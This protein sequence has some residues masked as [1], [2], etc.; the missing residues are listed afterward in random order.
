[1]YVLGV[2]TSCDET[3]CAVVQ[4]GKKILS[5]IVAS[6][7]EDHKPYGGI[8]PEIA[9]RSHVEFM[10]AVLERALKKARLCYEDIGLISVTNGP[11]LPGSLLVGLATAKALSFAKKIPLLGVDHL[12]A[13]LYACLMRPRPPRFPLVGMVVSG[14]HTSIFNIEAVDRFK[15]IAET[16]DDACGEAFDKVAKMLGLGY[17]GGPLIERRARAGN[18][19]AFSFPPPIAH[20]H[21][22]NFSFSGIKTAVLYKIKELQGM[23]IQPKGKRR[24]KDA[25]PP[26]P[27]R[28]SVIDD[29]CASFQKVVIETLMQRAQ[30]ACERFCA[31][32]LLLGG[33]VVSNQALREE[34]QKRFQRAG[35][36]V[37]FPPK[38]LSLDNAAMVAGLGYQLFRKG[39]RSSLDLACEPLGANY[40][41]A[42]N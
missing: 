42:Q 39:S 28:P 14:G 1:M 25:I 8:I 21:S 4:N 32:T 15:K 2:E 12:Q 11:G 31:N 7:L 3:A 13:H 29:L 41:A 24:P 40:S 36:G 37:L 33:G 19:K 10:V 5:N 20:P 30:L 27:L 16:Q 38:G 18:P 17:P 23:Q 9:C 35:L 34:F 6:S 26:K 22:L